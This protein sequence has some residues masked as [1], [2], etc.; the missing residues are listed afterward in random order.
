M[1]SSDYFLEI[2]NI[3][4]RIINES[5]DNITIID[6]NGDHK[7]IS[8]YNTPDAYTGLIGSDG[9]YVLSKDIIGHSNLID[10]ILHHGED[11][12]Q[13]LITNLDDIYDL[14]RLVRERIK[15]RIWKNQKVFSMWDYYKP[16][17]ETA[18]KNSL[19]AIGQNYKQYRY[20]NEY[21]DYNDMP[22]YD[23]FFVN[24]L[25]DEQ[26]E[27]NTMAAMKKIEAERALMDKIAGARQRPSNGET[28]Y[29]KPSW[30]NREGD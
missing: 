1:R 11:I 22:L 20:D 21:K 6:D 18:I 2:S 13:K 27:E 9:E 23:T 15:I 4:S 5:P 17:Y 8:Y 24:S 12:I 26:K 19:K 3:Y 10:H 29:R 7:N 16:S 14:Q 30:M 25:T 28:P